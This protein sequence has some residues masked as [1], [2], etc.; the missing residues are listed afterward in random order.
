MSKDDLTADLMADLGR[1]APLP[2]ALSAPSVLPAPPAAATPAFTL[3][4][5][6]LRWSLPGLDATERGLGVAVKAGPVRLEVAL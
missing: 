5:T 3:T 2:T 4:V 6:P 1:P